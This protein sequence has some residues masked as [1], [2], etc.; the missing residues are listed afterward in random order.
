MMLSQNIKNV[1]TTKSYTLEMT[2]NLKK[3]FSCITTHQ[4]NI[5]NLTNVCFVIAAI[6]LYV[7]ALYIW[8]KL[9]QF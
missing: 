2:F 9:F 4:I 3:L 7:Y 6:Y 1:I 8:V 5:L